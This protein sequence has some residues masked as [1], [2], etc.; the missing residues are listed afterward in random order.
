MTQKDQRTIETLKRIP[1]LDGWRGIA[2]ILV[3]ATHAQK[4]LF[5]GA[6]GG[7]K[8]LFFG[9]H[10][11]AIFFVLSGYL[12][13]TRILNEDRFSL[14]RFYQRRFFRL[15]PAA[16]VYLIAIALFSLVSGLHV[17]GSDAAACVFFFRNYFPLKESSQNAFTG[18]FWS[19]SVEEQF[20][21]VW[22]AVLAA[23][24]RRKA[25]Y[26]AA[27]GALVCAGYR[28]VYWQAYNR[29]NFDARS[30]VIFDG[31]L[32]GCILAILLQEDGVKAWFARFYLPLL[33]FCAVAFPY[34]VANF[35]ELI[36]LRESLL[37]ATA[38][39]CTVTVPECGFSR[40][41]DRPLLSALGKI[42]YS[43]YLWQEFFVL[44]RWAP[45][46]LLLLP[47]AAIASWKL[48]EQP[49]IQWGRRLEARNLPYC[50]VISEPMH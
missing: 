47:I 6:F 38:I 34:F 9:R 7:H 14:K 41:L 8:W 48:I 25:L 30:E 17:I 12:I 44:P 23:T 27:A 22:P 37:I 33:L 21:L 40:I 43:L 50:N 11:V 46:G 42:S 29:V 19:L 10:G 1:T 5:G 15:M 35:Q 3:I 16:W 45:I 18:H 32:V 2:I 31:L 28:L 20:Y 36:P 13:T 24:G 49:S 4:G 39:G 26:I